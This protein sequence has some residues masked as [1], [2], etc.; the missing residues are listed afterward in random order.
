[1]IGGVDVDMLPV[2]EVAPGKPVESDT[3][4]SPFGKGPLQFPQV[5]QSTVASSHPATIMTT[6]QFGNPD[7]NKGNSRSRRGHSSRLGIWEWGIGFWSPGAAT[8][9]G[10]DSCATDESPRKDGGKWGWL[11]ESYISKV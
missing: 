10:V 8:E 3:F 4:T 2:T 9:E 5:Y 7:P 6:K 11:V 1:M